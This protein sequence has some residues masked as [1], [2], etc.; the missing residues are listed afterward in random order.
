MAEFPTTRL[1]LVLAAA[2]SDDALAEL[3]RIY[4][5]PLYAFLRRQGQD[6]DRA[7]DLTQGFVA[8]LLGK[9]ALREFRGERGRFRSFLLA[10][11]KNFLANERD[12]AAA[13]K[14]G[15]GVIA[16]PLDSGVEPHDD[17]TPEKLFEK[18]WALAVLDR[19]QARLREEFAQAGKRELFDRLRAY[20]TGDDIGMPY[21]ELGRE[22]GLSEGA[23][24][25][26][27]HRLR[28]RFHEVLRDEIS[29]TVTRPGD[30]GDEIRYL[31]AA[32]RG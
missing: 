10:S 19:V 27:I 6:H 11:L 4:W 21:R 25:V 3:L 20:L 29:L 5:H 2:D 8:H 13:Q 18:Q 7:Q 22:L 32:I 16:S 17:R 30:I 24:K 9:G 12:R 26:T 14:R 31:I 23:V 28:R 1:S 15:G